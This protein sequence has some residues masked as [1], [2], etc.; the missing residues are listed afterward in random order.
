LNDV[1]GSEHWTK[2]AFRGWPANVVNEA[3]DDWDA[4][5]IVIG[6]GRHSAVDRLF[7]TETAINVIEHAKSS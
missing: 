7:G 4:S 6:L 3:A 2:R 5:L 1:S